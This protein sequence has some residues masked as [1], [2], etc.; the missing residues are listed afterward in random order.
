MI[1]LILTRHG[2]T[3]WNR[4]GKLAGSSNNSRLTPRAYR[5]TRLLAERLKDFDID[6]IYSS[7]LK[8]AVET[9]KIIAK[10]LNKKVIYLFG[11]NERSWGEYEG[12]MKDDVFRKLEEMDLEARFNYKPKGG[13]SWRGFEERL[14]KSFKKIISENEGKTV[15]VVFHAGATRTILPVLMKA[16]REKSFTYKIAN[17]SLTILK[18]SEG[19]VIEAL[20]DDISH[21]KT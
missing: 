11:L 2:E 9:S 10:L 21:L 4:A 1:T 18:M 3:D 20:I 5:E 15:L 13:E 16:P 14:D 19:K 8:R 7:K 17:N 12:Q 6:V